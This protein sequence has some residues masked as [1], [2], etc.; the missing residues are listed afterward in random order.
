MSQ[1]VCVGRHLTKLCC[2][3]S[4]ATTK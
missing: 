1:F 2:G 4:S 3:Q